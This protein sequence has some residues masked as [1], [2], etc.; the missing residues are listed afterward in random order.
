MSYF[1]FDSHSELK[2][3]LVP[4]GAKGLSAGAGS[5]KVWAVHCVDT[6]VESKKY[7]HFVIFFVGFGR[8]CDEKVNKNDT[9][10]SIFAK[11]KSSFGDGEKPFLWRSWGF[12][13]CL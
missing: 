12:A 5:R 11:L 2:Q 9:P 1:S 7:L 4:K 3:G 13:R 6:F 10:L 8:S